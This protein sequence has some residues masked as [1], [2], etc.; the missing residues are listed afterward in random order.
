MVGWM[1]MIRCERYNRLVQTDK[2]YRKFSATLPCATAA[3]LFP[4]KKKKTTDIK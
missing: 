3:N 2:V 4:V 1:I